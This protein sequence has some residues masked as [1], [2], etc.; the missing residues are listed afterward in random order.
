[1][2]V[3][4]FLI[5]AFDRGPYFAALEAHAGVLAA[6]GSEPDTVVVSFNSEM[7]AV[8]SDVQ[9]LKTKGSPK[10]AL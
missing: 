10:H 6:L 3:Y 8:V 9:R 7:D 1:M 5:L 2:G 4:L